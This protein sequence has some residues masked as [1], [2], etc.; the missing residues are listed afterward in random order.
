MTCNSSHS[1]SSKVSNDSG[2]K[3]EITQV[4]EKLTRRAY[5]SVYLYTSPIIVTRCNACNNSTM[6]A[7]KKCKPNLKA[8]NE[9]KEKPLTPTYDRWINKWEIKHRKADISLELSLRKGW[10]NVLASEETKGCITRLMC[11]VL[12]TT[13]SSRDL[14]D[15]VYTARSSVRS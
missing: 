6:L 1:W 5:L 8:I 2:E 10:D 12:N 7:S 14:L 11:C 4:H 15:I 13:R 9:N 3:R